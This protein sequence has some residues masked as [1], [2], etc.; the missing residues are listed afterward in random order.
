MKTYLVVY[1][2]A[3]DGT[4]WVRVPD[5]SGCYSCGDTTHEAKANIKEAIELYLETAKDEGIEIPAP[6]HF[7]AEMVEVE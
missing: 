2:K 1:E 3:N 7:E 5:L 4:I 6:Y